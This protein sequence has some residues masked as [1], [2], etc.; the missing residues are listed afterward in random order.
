MN[1]NLD[2]QVGG[3]DCG[4]AWKRGD[5]N[6][7]PV[8]GVPVHQSRRSGAINIHVAMAHVAVGPH[9]DLSMI[10]MSYPFFAAGTIWNVASMEGGTLSHQEGGLKDEAD[11][12]QA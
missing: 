2:G 6:S 7:E 4:V 12:G 8:P 9:L 10:P 3:L 1:T 5:R 11:G